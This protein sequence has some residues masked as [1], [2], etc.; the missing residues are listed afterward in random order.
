VLIDAIGHCQVRRGQNSRR[1]SSQFNDGIKRQKK[2]GGIIPIHTSSRIRM[3]LIGVIGRCQ[4][5]TGTPGGPKSEILA[6]ILKRSETP[7]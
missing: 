2:T 3:A 1:T 5:G 4:D 7:K 6:E